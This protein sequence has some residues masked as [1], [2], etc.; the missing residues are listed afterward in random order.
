M[1]STSAPLILLATNA[2]RVA[3]QAGT[4]AALL[5]TTVPSSTHRVR[6]GE[7]MGLAVAG[8]L[9][10]IDA[11]TEP[12]SATSGYGYIRQT[13]ALAAIT[14]REQAAV[15]FDVAKTVARFTM[16]TNFASSGGTRT[17]CAD[18]IAEAILI[19]LLDENLLANV[20]LA[21]FQ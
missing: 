10:V 6:D 19:A 8:A 20:T 3:A 4:Q 17:A 12:T 18:Q 2:N 15:I 13:G 1:T 14:P 5:G 16:P 7:E 21:D 9:G 11:L